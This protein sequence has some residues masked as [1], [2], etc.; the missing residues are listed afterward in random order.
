[1]LQAVLSVLLAVAIFVYVIVSGRRAKHGVLRS[2]TKTLSRYAGLRKYKTLSDLYVAHDGKTVYLENMLV[3]P[4]GILLL[5]TFESS[6]SYYGTVDAA[7]WL[8]KDSDQ[9]TRGTNIPNPLKEQEEAML[10]LR[11]LFSKNKIYNVPIE[12][13]LCFPAQSKNVNVYVTNSGEILMPGKLGALLQRERFEYDNG[14]DAAQICELILRHQT[15]KPEEPETDAQPTQP[16]AEETP[17]ET[18]SAPAPQDTAAELPAQEPPAET[19]AEQPVETAAPS[20]EQTPEEAPLTADAAPEPN[21]QAEQAAQPDAE[22][23]PAQ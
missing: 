22:Q 8:R 13:H 14:V 20:P 9:S 6:G 11:S 15:D 21:A 16:P 19:V 12:N 4:F 17:A 7:T 18:V 2:T 5:T 1:M 23:A 3:G 10:L